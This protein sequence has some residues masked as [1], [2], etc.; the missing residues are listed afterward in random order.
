MMSQ[1]S[2]D[3]HGVV[4]NLMNEKPIIGYNSINMRIMLE[5]ST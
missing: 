4:I 5:L 2:L 3:L 1:I